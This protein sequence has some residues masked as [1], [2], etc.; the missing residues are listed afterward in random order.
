MLLVIS[1]VLSALISMPYICVGCFLNEVC[2]ILRAP[3]WLHLNL[4]QLIGQEEGRI[5]RCIMEETLYMYIL[6]RISSVDTGLKRA[7]IVDDAFRVLGDIMCAQWVRLQVLLIL[8]LARDD[9]Y[10]RLL[11]PGISY[12][13]YTPPSVWTYR[14]THTITSCCRTYVGR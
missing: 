5:D 6:T 7:S 10:G 2:K 13:N 8:G 11:L 14:N 4:M 12:G 1:F 9:V 3:S